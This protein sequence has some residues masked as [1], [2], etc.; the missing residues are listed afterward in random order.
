MRKVIKKIFFSVLALLC[1]GKLYSQNDHIN[2]IP[3]SPQASSLGSFGKVQ[4]N[5]VFGKINY[6]IPLF[7]IKMG[8][9]EFPISLSYNYSGYQPSEKRGIVGRGWNINNG[10]IISVNIR[11]IDDF[12]PFGYLGYNLIGKT[13]VVPFIDGSLRNSL[14]PGNFNDVINRF[15]D[16][17]YDT[18]PDRYTFSAGKIY[19]SFFINHENKV[20][21]VDGEQLNVGF[22]NEDTPDFKILDNYGNLYLFEKSETT[23][24]EQ[25]MKPQIYTT[26]Y[27]LTQIK[28]KENKTINF[29]FIHNL[30][31]N[32]IYSIS[33]TEML[34]NNYDEPLPPDSFCRYEQGENFLSWNMFHETNLVYEI[35]YEKNRIIFEYI[36][37]KG[38]KLL[39]KIKI[40]NED[41]KIK[42]YE[43]NYDKTNNFLISLTSKDKTDMVIDKHQFEY[44]DIDNF[45]NRPIYAVDYYGYYNGNA[46]KNFF[47]RDRKVDFNKTLI[48]ALKR[49]TYPTNGYTEFSY[50]SNYHYGTKDNPERGKCIPENFTGVKTIFQIGEGTQKDSIYVEQSGNI[51]IELLTRVD[52]MER[53]FTIAKAKAS[54][55]SWSKE[56]E[57]YV[58]IL[59]DPRQKNQTIIN[60]HQECLHVGK[61][62]VVLEVDVK[63]YTETEENKKHGE[64]LVGVYF[65][66]NDEKINTYPVG[67]LRVEKMK[68]CDKNDV[69]VEKEYDYNNKDGRPSSVI[70]FMPHYDYR[71][72][73]H[74]MPYPEVEYVH[75]VI[76]NVP[77]LHSYSGAPVMYKVVKEKI[78]G[79]SGM[80][81]ENYIVS[82]T[83]KYQTYPFLPVDNFL[84]TAG[85]LH[86][87]NVYEE[88]Q[89][90]ES[91][92]NYYED[93]KHAS[94]KYDKVYG[95]S[96][97]RY[98]IS[99]NNANGSK[100]Y[101]YVDLSDMNYKN[102]YLNNN[103]KELV[104]TEN[105]SF[106]NKDSIKILHQYE[107]YNDNKDRPI[108]LKHEKTTFPNG[109]QK[110]TS[111]QYAHEKGNNYLINKNIV[112]IPLETTVTQDG[113]II[114][115]TETIY[116]T[117]QAEA[118]IKTQGLPL[119][120]SSLSYDLEN[121]TKTN[122]DITYTQY[123][124]KGNLLE[125]KLNGITP[126]VIIWGYHQTLPIAKIEGATYE[127]VKNLVS[128]IISKSNED[129]DEVSEKDLITALDNF[130]NK[131]EL[132]NFQ[133][134]TYTHNPLIGVTSITPPSGIREIY[135]YDD[136]N[137][138]KQVLDIEGNILKEYNYHYSEPYKNI[139]QSK[140]FTRNNCP[141]GYIGDDYNYIVPAGKYISLISQDDADRK[142][143][144]D[145]NTNGLREANIHASC[146]KIYYNSKRGEY[147]DRQNCNELGVDFISP[148]KYYYEVP[149]GKYIS[150]ISQDDADQKALDD[151]K[152][153]GQKEANL[154]A[155]C[156]YKCNFTPITNY[157][158]NFKSDYMNVYLT[159]NNKIKLG[160]GLMPGH[161]H[162]DWTQEV[163][164]G[165]LPRICSVN[166]T[167]N[168]TDHDFEEY[169]VPVHGMNN[170][171][172]IARIKNNG[173]I[174]LQI[175]DYNKLANSQYKRI[176]HNNPDRSR[177][178]TT[179][180]VFEWDKNVRGSHKTT[181]YNTIQSKQFLRNNCPVG[182]KSESYTYTV[183]S[184]KY[185]S[186][187]SQEDADQKAL[188]EI[189]KNGQKEANL[190]AKC[191]PDI[192]SFTPI[193][194][195]YFDFIK[196]PKNL[197]KEGNKIKLIIGLIPKS[198]YLNWNEEIVIGKL[199]SCFP[200][201]EVEDVIPILKG[202][203]RDKDR[204]WII[205]I[206]T[207]G[208][209]SLQ[210]SN[211]DA[212][213]L[214]HSR[215]FHNEENTNIN[216]RL[217]VYEF[218]IN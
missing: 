185:F 25:D 136:A 95:F 205:R 23:I 94:Q 50:S 152:K 44:Y 212:Y 120:V 16:N 127:Q 34:K 89:K 204:R 77:A 35:T 58:H 8:D 52:P 209:V 57:T 131:D 146:K 59:E 63:D 110:N 38:E 12:S 183:P 134:T 116:P 163:T 121:P 40:Y 61:G 26:A 67:G 109:T 106:Y 85:R 69:C 171:N 27:N 7:D 68:D 180:L 112:G 28:T 167:P 179:F 41:T 196:S 141:N 93:V 97:Y 81:E 82:N 129:K 76:N 72:K 90:K 217:V 104:K 184:G 86:K 144:E 194:S 20:V 182:Y 198:K 173:D 100:R 47:E 190:N 150:L 140:T 5:K 132:K 74:H 156:V 201:T 137:R 6:S 14:S 210:I 215:D 203:V 92:Q 149:A 29:K 161:E 178:N 155:E 166:S 118:N 70:S 159:K 189:N 151:I 135:K 193:K 216:R 105:R 168:A 3:N 181:F 37:D 139:I 53:G 115:K 200:T 73:C 80:I 165:K 17:E 208:E 51:R 98:N 108:S 46:S 48:G 218:N 91:Q 125:Y 56:V 199:E 18:E 33:K 15:L 87:R 78:K 187:I 206:K 114:S 96:K 65:E 1:W 49:I 213:D 147:F 176:F 102:Y 124:N 133:I 36:D 30:V 99:G 175:E 148:K 160:L 142:A 31:K 54:Y 19:S 170:I 119:P 43:F 83:P 42:D 177:N 71:T 101:F 21:T 62:Y 84:Y 172:W 174:S 79:K 154:N 128:D 66:R 32:D 192:C 145:L 45:I 60:Q 130:R 9:Y 107:Y 186:T 103:Y 13:M 122:Q 55:K 111:Y 197:S 113:K 2:F 39:K 126:V 211:Y 88:K 123:D 158:Y 22:K 11:G 138:L 117:S 207:T 214:Y 64:A 169:I 195:D 157:Y 24:N 153:N 10:G 162:L 188:D 202:N 164:I 191:V 75:K 4:L 143:I